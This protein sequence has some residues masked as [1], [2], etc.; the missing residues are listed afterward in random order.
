M[1]KNTSDI[2]NSWMII[3]GVA[4]ICVVFIRIIYNL[5]KDKL[6]PIRTVKAQVVDK[7][8]VDN[9]SKIYGSLAKKPQYF[10]VFAIGKRK[11]SFRVSEFSY[12]G[13]KV[14]EK[15][16]LRYKGSKIVFFR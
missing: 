6:A 9:F 13:Y 3:L 16:T 2:I 8:I 1:P 7:F 11:R 12:G 14:N 15:G 4:C 5:L 10:I